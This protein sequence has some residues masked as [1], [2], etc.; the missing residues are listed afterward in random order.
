MGIQA[1]DFADLRCK[2]LVVSKLFEN[3]GLDGRRG[4][5]LM[6]LLEAILHYQSPPV[7]RSAPKLDDFLF[8]PEPVRYRATMRDEFC[9]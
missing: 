9:A 8:C 2:A 7:A 3:A 1:A 6:L 5:A 4:A